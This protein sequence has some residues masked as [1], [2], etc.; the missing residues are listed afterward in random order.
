M[1]FLSF[2]FSLLFLLLSFFLAYLPVFF[3]LSFSRDEL[4][5]MKRV[6]RR[7]GYVNADNVIE[8]KVIIDKN[9]EMVKI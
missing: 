6:L 7:L 2:F 8:V 5:C 3:S 4:K 9:K 1:R